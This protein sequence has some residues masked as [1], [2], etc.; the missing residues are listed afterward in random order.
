MLFISAG[1]IFMNIHKLDLNIIRG[2]GR[3]KPLL[4]CAFL[5]GVLGIAGVP[6]FSGYVS[7]TLVHE[8]MVEYIHM[9]SEGHADAIVYGLGAFRFMEWLFLISGG[10]TLAYMLKL[11][12]CIFIEKNTD[13]LLQDKYDRM[14]AYVTPVSAALITIS[15]MIFPILGLFPNR[16]FDKLADMGQRFM[17]LSENHHTVHYFT[18]VNLK[19]SLISL[20][21]GVILYVLVVRGLLMKNDDKG[22]FYVDRWNKFLDLENMV[23]RPLLGIV[24][25]TCSILFRICDRLVDWIVVALRKTI[26][27]DSKLPHELSEGTPITHTIG[28]ILDDGEMIINKTIRRKNPFKLSFEHKLAL[29]NEEIGEN[30]TIIGRSLSF[31]LFMFCLGLILTLAYMLWA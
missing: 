12:I 14:T 26:Y 23:Y 22:N 16:L 3:K 7:K 18:W 24:E 11:Y 15:A 17:N 27:R 10:M 29:V 31:G 13:D 8:S 2:F 6:F 19:G 25:I 1:V 21:I 9:L 28:V 5:C 30:N 20:I 4:H